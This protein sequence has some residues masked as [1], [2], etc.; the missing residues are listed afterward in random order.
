MTTHNGFVNK[1]TFADV[2]NLMRD[3]EWH[4]IRDLAESL[5]GT[6]PP[7]MA[8]AAYRRHKK[9]DHSGVPLDAQVLMGIAMMVSNLS[10]AQIQKG[11][12][13]RH[14]PRGEY[15]RIR[16]VGWY[17]WA[18]GKRTPAQA[19]RPAHGLCGECKEGGAPCPE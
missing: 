5:L 16:V 7:E 3:R 9:G 8:T 13:E 17:C 6:V 12:V 10:S 19:E 11:A 18:C 2:R 1:L 15:S 4:I 14:G